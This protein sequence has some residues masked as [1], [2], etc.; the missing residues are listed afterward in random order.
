MACALA[1]SCWGQAAQAS[2]DSPP[3]DRFAIQGQTTFTEQA[4]PAFPSPFEG[5]NSLD[6]VANGRE[7]WDATLFLGARLWRNAE[8]WID[9]ETDQGFGLSDTLGVAGF[10]SAEAY[11]VGR[12]DPYFRLQRFF[13]RD[14]IDLGGAPGKVDADLNQFAE[15]DTAD[16]LV[17]TVGKFAVTDIFD[18]NSYAHNSRGDFLNWSIIDAGTFDYAADS[19]GYSTG[20]AAEWYAGRW[21]LRGG[22]FLLSNLPNSPYIDTRFD[23]FQLV[24]EIEERHD[25]FGEPGKLLVTAFLSRARM[26]LYSAAIALAEADGGPPS[27]ALVR[28]Y[29]SRPGVSLDLEQRIFA[30]LGAFMRAG[31]AD[32][33]YETYEFSDIDRTVSGGLSL[34]GAKWGRSKDTI[35]LAGVVNVA[36]SQLETYLAAG[37]LGILVGDGRLPNPGTERILETYYAL[38]VAGRAQVTLDYQWITNPGYDRDRGP[39]SVLALRLHGQF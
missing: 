12:I 31:W 14:T 7:T 32:G 30:D 4:H 24:G 28:H 8:V 29:A 9:P 5:P 38:A 2:A 10:P 19:W 26:G 20:A 22:S 13:V 23:Q 36:S 3:D 6:A 18:A 16:R 17:V 33:R 34:T 25:I 37:G 35:G 27:T 11:K 15:D 21:T 39:A 1:G